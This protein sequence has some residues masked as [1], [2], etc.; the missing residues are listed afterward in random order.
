MAFSLAVSRLSVYHRRRKGA[1]ER[2]ENDGDQ[3]SG[4]GYVLLH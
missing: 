1:R 3:E 4:T 2:K